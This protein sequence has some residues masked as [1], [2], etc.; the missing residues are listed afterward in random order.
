MSCVSGLDLEVWCFGFVDLRFGGGRKLPQRGVSWCRVL[1]SGLRVEG[2]GL[3]V[4]G[5]GFREG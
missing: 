2:L 4:E 1:G 3:R 5:L